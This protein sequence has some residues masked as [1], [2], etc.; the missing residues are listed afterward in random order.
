M[1]ERQLVRQFAKDLQD[2]KDPDVFFNVMKDTYGGH[3]KPFDAFACFRGEFFAF[4]FKRFDGKL[5][6]HQKKALA[7]VNAAG[8][9][10]FEAWFSKSRQHI[11]FCF[12]GEE[13]DLFWSKSDRGWFPE[14]SDVQEL[15][16]SLILAAEHA[17]EAD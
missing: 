9:Y 14:L 4:E 1:T 8:G 11:A 7:E 12:G 6:E 13:Y 5:E 2:C 10:G 15:F 17:R 3:K 16:G